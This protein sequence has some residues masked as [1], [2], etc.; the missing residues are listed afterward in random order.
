MSRARNQ[1]IRPLVRGTMPTQERRSRL[2]G[3]FGEYIP[4]DRH[5]DILRY[6]A[7]WASP[8]DLYRD[9][10]MIDPAQH[11]AGLRFGSA[12]QRAVSSAGACFERS[13][14]IDSPTSETQSK[15]LQRALAYVEQAYNTLSS[16]TVDIVID[17]CAYEQPV[18][19]PEALNKLSKGLGRLAVS[20]HLAAAEL[21]ERMPN[22]FND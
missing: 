22:T 20:W 2:G 10:Q 15:A 12:Y 17:V 4:H 8:L 13:R 6:R 18:S 19:S 1:K 14:R 11:Q 3:I 16:D 5:T 9:R 7:R 21:C